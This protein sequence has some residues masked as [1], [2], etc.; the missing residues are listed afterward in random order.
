V[1]GRLRAAPRAR[2][3]RRHWLVP[4]LADRSLD[5]LAC[6][7]VGPGV[8]LALEMV[9]LEPRHLT[10]AAAVV[11]RRRAGGERVRLHRP[12]DA[13]RSNYASRMHLGRVFDEMGADHD[14]RPVRERDLA[15]D[16][17]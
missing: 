3:T 12:V 7:P 11:Y 1:P 6:S 14:L 10:S 13:D 17:L 8:E 2:S 9:W 5:C 16:L 15:G 4:P